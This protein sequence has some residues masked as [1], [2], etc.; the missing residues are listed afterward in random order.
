MGKTLSIYRKLTKIPGGKKIFSKV[1]TFRVPYFST[2]HPRIEELQS[3]FCKVAIK[4]RRSI[5]NHLKT[6]NAGALCTLSELTVGLAVEASLPDNL[7]WIPKG[8]KV[9]YAKKAKGHVTST[10]SFDPLTLAPGEI[11]LQVAITDSS[12]ELVCQSEINFHISKRKV[13]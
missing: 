2:I 6:I 9:E 1:L 12:N 7:R 8:M 5:H 3:G 11:G 10:C 13:T 4:D